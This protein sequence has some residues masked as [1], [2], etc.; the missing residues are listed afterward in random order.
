[1]QPESPKTPGAGVARAV[2]EPSLPSVSFPQEFELPQILSPERVDVLFDEKIGAGLGANPMRFSSAGALQ[3]A[4]DD[5]ERRFENS[6][7]VQGIRKLEQWL[8]GLPHGYTVSLGYYKNEE[9]KELV[10]TLRLVNRETGKYGL[11]DPTPLLPRSIDE[12]RLER[13]GEAKVKHLMEASS[14]LAG[15]GIDGGMRP[16]STPVEEYAAD[17]P[18]QLVFTHAAD[19]YSK[20]FDWHIQFG[21]AEGFRTA[22]EEKVEFPSRSHR[23][24]ARPREAILPDPELSEEAQIAALRLRPGRSAQHGYSAP[25]QTSAESVL[26]DQF[27]RQIGEDLSRITNGRSH[28]PGAFTLTRWAGDRNMVAVHLPIEYYDRSI[29]SG[30]LV[31]AIGVDEL[32][33]PKF[34]LQPGHSSVL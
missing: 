5:A 34:T 15:D 10:V 2:V 18:V 28:A 33:R 27:L 29:E 31:Y 14:R 30:R 23:G 4:L 6:G 9:D 7:F 3:M 21:A 12:S 25:V 11:V 32:G 8:E 26:R 22:F 24:T 19:N 17:T 16:G 20:P 13:P 1:M